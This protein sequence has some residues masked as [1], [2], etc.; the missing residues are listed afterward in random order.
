[1]GKFIKVSRDNL[2]EKVRQSLS[3]YEVSGDS[4]N[5]LMTG[6]YHLVSYMEKEH[7]SDYTSDVGVSYLSTINVEKGIA[8]R[9][10]QRD[11]RAIAMLDS[12]IS[13]DADSF[14]R[15]QRVPVKRIFRGE[16]AK[17]IK[18]YIENVL[19]SRGLAKSTEDA[20]HMYLSRFCEEM[21]S[22]NFS[23]ST[24]TRSDLNAYISRVT[25]ARRY[26][27]ALPVKYFLKYLH[28]EGLVDGS[29]S[30]CLDG[31]QNRRYVPLV[32]YFEEEEILRMENSITRAGSLGKRNYAMFL[33]S[34]RLGLRCADVVNLKLSNIDWDRNEISLVQQ[35]TQKPIVLP[36]TAEVGEALV[37]YLTHGRP[38]SK[39]SFV[40][41][42]ETKRD[43][44]ITGHTFSKLVSDSMM[45][46]G[47]DI[48]ERHHSA[49]SLRHSL[50]THLMKK[51]V[52]MPI[53]KEILGHTTTEPTYAYLAVDHDALLLC[54]MDV[55]KVR[56]I[57]YS[58]KGGMI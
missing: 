33:L 18:S 27:E 19:P 11:K 31:I 41:L 10:Y 15:K 25:T 49:H 16:F 53:I 58:Q 6:I 26:F 3:G 22:K 56:G 29:I 47:I 44:P 37:D 39:S 54:S 51:K 21:Y 13:G 30:T 38:N 40:F 50:A 42:S 2:F 14:F 55:P 7:L 36:L 1:M 12:I 32:S 4:Q 46:A 5:R 52:K 48:R 57:I 24:I 23:P 17:H 28:E 8:Y 35:K 20:Y 34:A 43:R 45:N 9:H